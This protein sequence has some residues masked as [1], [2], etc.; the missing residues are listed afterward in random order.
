ML[1]CCAFLPQ[2]FS[3]SAAISSC[4]GIRRQRHQRHGGNIGG[5][6]AAHQTL[7]KHHR[8][9]QTWRRIAWRATNEQHRK[10]AGKN[11]GAAA[12]VRCASAYRTPLRRRLPRLCRIGCRSRAAY[13]R[14][15]LRLHRL[16][17]FSL[18]CKSDA[19]QTVAHAHIFMRR[20]PTAK[21]RRKTAHIAWLILFA[22]IS[23]ILVIRRAV[24]LTRR[25]AR[26]CDAAF[27]T[28][29]NGV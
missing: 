3:A 16:V 23:D 15:R 9:R 29:C 6:S 12:G 4:G 20:A 13:E 24:S 26:I 21:L 1:W 19:Y 27:L 11:I 8:H 2:L 25:F 18:F 7:A 14:L 28:W 17:I 5:A 22:T 10:T